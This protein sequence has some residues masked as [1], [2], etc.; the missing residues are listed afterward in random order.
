MRNYYLFCVP[1]YVRPWQLRTTTTTTTTPPTGGGRFKPTTISLMLTMKGLRSWN[2]FFQ[3][4]T[5]KRLTKPH[6]NDPEKFFK[7]ACRNIVYYETNLLFLSILILIL[8]TVANPLRTAIWLLCDCFIVLVIGYVF[9]TLIESNDGMEETL[10]SIAR[11][12]VTLSRRVGAKTSSHAASF[13]SLSV[14]GFLF[15]SSW[16]FGLR[17]VYLGTA[18]MI[19]LCVCSKP[20]ASMKLSFA[21][22][23]LKMKAPGAPSTVFGLLRMTFHAVAETHSDA[24]DS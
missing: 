3:A 23:M 1:V 12:V 22:E 4:L 6:V 7:R 24:S 20:T 10:E 13:F 15:I 17:F 11:L 14:L 18:C 19:L 16:S 8:S 9:G 2:D 21:S 5:G